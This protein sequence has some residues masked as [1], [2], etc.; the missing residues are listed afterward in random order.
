MIK[1][2]PQSVTPFDLTIANSHV[3]VI[4][5][6]GMYSVAIPV[7]TINITSQGHQAA[8]PQQIASH[9]EAVAHTAPLDHGEN[10]P[11]IVGS[12]KSRNLGL[13]DVGIIVTLGSRIAGG[14]Q[15]F[16]VI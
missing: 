10:T 16:G 6:I 2:N 15:G 5:V 11:L 8:R 9:G 1:F 14:M 12:T 4:V 3:L 7:L 13:P